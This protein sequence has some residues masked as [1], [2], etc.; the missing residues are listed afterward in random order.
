MMRHDRRGFTLI[1]LLIAMVLLLVV[2][3]AVYQLLI[4]TQR[5]SREQAQRA[6]VQ[7]NARAGSLILPAELREVGKDDNT[8]P[9]ILG[10]ATDSIA[11]R[12]IRSSG[13]IC[14]VSTDQIIVDTTRGYAGLR[15]PVAGRDQ[16]MLHA[17]K[18]V[19]KMSDDVWVRRPITSVNDGTCPSTYGSRLGLTLGTTLNTATD[20]IYAGSPMRTYERVVYKMYQVGGKNYLGTYSLAITGDVIQPVLGPLAAN[21]LQLVYYD[22]LGNT[23]V[24]ALADIRSIKITIKGMSDQKVAAAGGSGTP[25]EAIDSVWT[26]VTLRN[27]LR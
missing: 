17:E 5:I 25:S 26:L 22:S 27:T 7:S 15:R 13:I 8:N 21:G 4:R 23:P 10:A 12:A 9:D 2:G 11:F 1:E 19:T 14:S 18:D 24:A 20:G 3:T 6:D 16:L